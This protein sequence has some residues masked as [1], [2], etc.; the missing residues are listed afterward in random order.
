MLGVALILAVATI[1]GAMTPWLLFLLT[2]AL[3]AGDAL[4][5]SI[6]MLVGC[7]P[8]NGIFVETEDTGPRNTDSSRV[9]S[10]R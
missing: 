7:A 3:A 10:N 9:L 1:S 8:A 2:L 5:R 6:R 4:E